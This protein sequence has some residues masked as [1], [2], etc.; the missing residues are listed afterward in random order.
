MIFAFLWGRGG[1]SPNRKTLPNGVLQNGVHFGVTDLKWATKM[2][3]LSDAT[4][5]ALLH[6]SSPIRIRLS[7]GPIVLKA[8]A[9]RK[10]FSGSVDA[11][12]TQMVSTHSEP[13]ESE[14]R[15][16]H[17]LV[18][19]SAHAQR[20]SHQTAWFMSAALK[21]R[22]KGVQTWRQSSYRAMWPWVKSPYPQ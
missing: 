11:W 15:K 10:P 8:K 12:Q 1:G 19:S 13:V 9:E 22:G 21:P 20:G 5:M 16:E 2:G 17:G 4:H 6:C 3:F 14:G 18:S 7:P